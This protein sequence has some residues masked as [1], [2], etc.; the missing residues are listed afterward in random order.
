MDEELTRLQFEVHKLKQENR[1][2]AELLRLVQGLQLGVS[3]I[4]DNKVL[5]E[6]RRWET[7]NEDG[8]KRY[9]VIYTNVM[10]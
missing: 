7:T 3:H 5:L 4:P 10:E 6:Q 8:T 9:V 2:L 1:E